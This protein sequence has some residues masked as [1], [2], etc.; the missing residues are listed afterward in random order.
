M[1]GDKVLT[2]PAGVQ[3]KFK[4]LFTEKH[5]EVAKS[6]NPEEVDTFVKNSHHLRV[7]RGKRWGAFDADREALGT[8]LVLTTSSGPLTCAMGNSQLAIGS[9]ARDGDAPRVVGVD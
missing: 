2:R 4:K 8:L 6:A 7:L 5:P 3:E 1:Y 9:A